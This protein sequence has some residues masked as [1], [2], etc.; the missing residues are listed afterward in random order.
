MIIWVLSV[1]VG[2]LAG[3]AVPF[4]WWLIQKAGDWVG[5][6]DAAA[7]SM[8]LII[9][10]PATVSV[11]IL[12]LMI[13]FR[14]FR[15]ADGFTY[16]ISDLHFQD[17]RRK[18]RYS[19]VHS[20][21]NVIFV[22][23][24]AVVGI[25]GFCMEA[26]S[27]LGSWFGIKAKLSS[28]QIRTL[29]GCGATASIAAV[30]GQPMT[31]FIFVVELLYGWG[32][33]SFAVGMFAIAAFTAASV[34]Q[35]LS[36]GILR[37]GME[38]DA[39]LSITLQTES[40]YLSPLAAIACVVGFSLICGFL[41]SFSISVH[42]RTDQ[43]LHGLFVEK[44]G[45]DVA[46]APFAFRIFLWAILTG[47]VMYKFPLVLGTGE[48]LL[49]ESLAQGT[50]FSFIAFAFLLRILMGAMAYSVLGS[51]GMILPTLISGCLIGAGV[52]S[53][54]PGLFELSGG[55]LALL[56]MGGFFSA[57][58][59]T[60]VAATALVFSYSS[61]MMTDN[62]LFLFTA[63]LI[64][65]CSHYL[66]GKFQTDRLAS[67][68]LYRHGIR[69]RN[70][71]C[72]NTLSSIQVRDAMITYINPIAYQS[73]MGESYRKLMGSKYSVLPVVSDQGK[74]KGMISL[75]DFYGLDTWKKLGEDSQVHSLV[76]VEELVKTARV[77]LLPDM[78]LET[79]LDKMSDEE[80]AP[81]SERDGQYVGLLVK[82]DLVNL[83][84][85]E[86]VKKAFKRG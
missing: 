28:N 30:L 11:V 2:M 10:V 43:E 61:G 33:S 64:N 80:L 26:L 73:S 50:I 22:L 36:N 27:A 51:M 38:A 67:M 74:L 55:T 71:M 3:A 13:G 58:F 59:G 29:A 21:S 4:F 66:C 39:G 62:A 9:G 69:F 65:F 72:Y 12:L 34:S 48:L 24:Q 31:A 15:S 77:Q 25:E 1:A 86:V 76:G 8:H 14:G 17:G 32:S 6:L 20:L 44:K 40:F 46:P 79:A 49:N 7:W 41:A 70:G 63:I 52:Y 81:V 47:I 35:S 18:G 54:A 75:S 37:T 57:S 23:G 68:G 53:L 84:N 60:P 78:N 83:Y 16:F 82:S 42:R 56:A 45:V 85:K 5:R 19:F